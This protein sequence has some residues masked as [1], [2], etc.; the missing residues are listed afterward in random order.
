MELI[1]GSDK[2]NKTC[3]LNSIEVFLFS[4]CNCGF[5]YN[6]KIVPS[7]EKNS[8]AEKVVALTKI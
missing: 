4:G 1:R 3:G 7:A 6:Q 8:I 2:P 5:N